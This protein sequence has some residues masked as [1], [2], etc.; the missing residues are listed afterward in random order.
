MS[1]SNITGSTASLVSIVQ[2]WSTTVDAED[3]RKEE[4]GWVPARLRVLSSETAT[5][6]FAKRFR[7]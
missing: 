4:S 6:S 3:F 7:P 1:T 2:S 5:G